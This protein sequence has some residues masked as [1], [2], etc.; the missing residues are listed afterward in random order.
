MANLR[1]LLDENIAQ[2]V[3]HWLA[4]LRPGWHVF[5]V[6]GIG[7]ASRPDDEI[8]AWAQREGAIII[9]FDYDFGDQRL[10]PLGTHAG[11]VRLRVRPTTRESARRAISRLLESVAEDDLGGNLVVIDAAGIRVRRP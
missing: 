11:I 6:V 9:S 10:F 4:S 7:L 2:E 8:F 3:G 1:I 5:T